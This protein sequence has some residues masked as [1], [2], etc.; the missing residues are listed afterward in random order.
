MNPPWFRKAPFGFE[1]SVIVDGEVM[2]RLDQTPFTI[3]S[4]GVGVVLAAVPV[5]VVL[6]SAFV[7]VVFGPRSPVVMV[8]IGSVDP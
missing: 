1:L 7:T 6:P 4:F 5:M 8:A 3:S 2:P